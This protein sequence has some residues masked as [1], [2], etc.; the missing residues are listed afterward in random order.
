M[1]AMTSPWHRFPGLMMEQLQQTE[2]FR[3]HYLVVSS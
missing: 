1:T 2:S 3:E